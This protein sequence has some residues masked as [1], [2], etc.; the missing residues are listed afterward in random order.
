MTS[1]EQRIDTALQQSAPVWV[2]PELY[3]YW[4]ETPTN[5][6][7][8]P[9]GDI[10]VLTEQI[11]ETITIDHSLDDGLPDPVTMTSQNN[12]S[13]I[14]KVDLI[15]R[16]GKYATTIGWRTPLLVQANDDIGT[17]DTHNADWEWGDYIIIVF[18]TAD[19][20]TQIT[21][22]ES[23]D[24]DL[25]WSGVDA[26]GCR[27]F[28]FGGFYHS[29]SQQILLDFTPTSTFLTYSYVANA[30]YARDPDGAHVYFQAG[31][32]VGS[33]IPAPA[34]SH[35]TPQATLTGRGV[36]VGVWGAV[37]TVVGWTPG[38]TPAHTE[39]GEIVSAQAANNVSTMLSATAVLDPGQY[40]LTATSPSWTHGAYAAIP[41]LIKDVPT[42]TAQRYFSPFS[43]DSPIKDMERDTAG[44]DILLGALTDQ[45]DERTTVHWGQMASIVLKGQEAEMEV[46]SKTRLDLTKSIRPPTVWGKNE[47]ANLTWFVSWLM[48]Q[49]GMFPGP[50]PGATTRFWAPCYGSMHGIIEG[51]NSYYSSVLWD[52]LGTTF[53][54][55]RPSAVPGQYQLG[56]FG[57]QTAEQTQELWWR[58]V[59]SRGD[60]GGLSYH[61]DTY[62]KNLNYDFFSTADGAFGQFQCWVRGDAH[63]DNPSTYTLPV[64]DRLLVQM[65]LVFRDK[66]SNYQRMY[67]QCGV[68]SDNRRL[69]IWMGDDT[70]GILY[71]E[72][73]APVP[74]L[75]T[76]GAWHFVGISWNWTLGHCKFNLDGV[77]SVYTGAGFTT[78]DANNSFAS[79]EAYL[80]AG[81]EISL[82]VRA[83]LP[84]SDIEIGA[85]S[86]AYG[87]PWNDADN[88]ESGSFNATMIPANQE[89]EAIAIPA[90]EEGW[91][92][93]A[94]V[95]QGS[96][97]SYRV[98]EYDNL[99]FL[100]LSYF[101][102]TASMTPETVVDTEFNAGELDVQHDPSKTR[103]VITVEFD[104]TRVD[105]RYS[106]VLSSTTAETIPRGVSTWVFA[107]DVPAAAVHG[108]GPNIATLWTL[109][110]LTAVQVTNKTMPT[111]LNYVSINSKDDGTGTYYTS[112]DVTVKIL[113]ADSHSVTVEFT[114]RTNSPR[115]LTN[116]GDGVPYLC[117]YGYAIRTA[118]GYVTVRDTSSESKRRER[119]L[120]TKVPWIQRRSEAHQY[121]MLLL[122]M[123]CKPRAE[124]KV[125]VMG[126][127]NR[128][129]GQLVTIADS[130]GTQTAG[131]WRI[132]AVSHQRNG[133]EYIQ[134]LSLVHVGN[135][136]VWTGT[137]EDG[138]DSGLWAP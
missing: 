116:N 15:G 28:V 31:T 1:P 32:P 103:N 66:P 41:L 20:V 85:G 72:A 138:W 96:L 4:E 79:E 94:E 129:P 73:P 89:L 74:V 115:F 61:R 84:I 102:T 80:A 135:R 127:P 119:A 100:P 22:S 86:P 109:T 131:N 37:S 57:C 97:S 13:G 68:K 136:A 132:L 52:R 63:V 95:A 120:S 75:P 122:N 114:N 59:P 83:H 18:T 137:A 123:L 64:G 112:A 46:V 118:P 71:L 34:T 121:A 8:Q 93:L 26:S 35:T 126:N 117:I 133:A 125:R 77:E 69:F 65:T 24:Y 51:F 87:N 21:V 128:K 38:G 47:G 40:A 42:M 27:V 23:D 62:G 99:A 2:P 11:G 56:M 50:A 105:D 7:Y 92:M 130:Q 54:P 70:G 49:A 78:T 14:S 76:D 67:V 3:V 58:L 45:G 12:A 39:L 81:H 104:E 108:A 33:T 91:G 107:L 82:S 16:Y 29:A 90:P 10:K 88:P 113:T 19:M 5:Y 43:A 30:I 111:T 44:V 36:V 134:D 9:P 101:G 53:R 55:N 60:K 106:P 98:D 48:A 25:L 6:P 110:N 17:F 124:V